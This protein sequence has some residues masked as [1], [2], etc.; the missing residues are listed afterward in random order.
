MEVN[1]YKVLTHRD[2][3]AGGH[4]VEVVGVGAHCHDLWQYRLA[5]PF[6]TKDLCELLEIVRRSLSDGEDRVAEP[7]HAKTTELL[8]EELDAKLAG[9][10]GDVLNDGQS[11]APLLVFGKLYDSRQQRL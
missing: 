8:V 11:D 4:S 9:Q 7:A 3:E 1:D 2:G 6:D 5:G 10:Q